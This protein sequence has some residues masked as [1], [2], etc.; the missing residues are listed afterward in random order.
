MTVPVL[1]GPFGARARESPNRSK[2]SGPLFSTQW[3]TPLS[4]FR[5]FFKWPAATWHGLHGLSK[6]FG[7]CDRVAIVTV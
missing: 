5:G 3:A 4:S 2:P 1:C 6:D 7:S